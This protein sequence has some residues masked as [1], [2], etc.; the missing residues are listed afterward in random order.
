[1]RCRAVKSSRFYP[2]SVAL[3]ALTLVM[4]VASFARVH[5]TPVPSATPTAGPEN[6]VVTAIA[7]K[8]FLSWQA[9]I[10]DRSKYAPSLLVQIDDAKLKE[11]STNLGRLGP[12]VQVTY[13]GRMVVDHA[14]SPGYTGYLYHFTTQNGAVYEQ[15]VLDP[16]NA[17]AGIIFLDKLPSP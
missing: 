8:Q 11:V 15:L 2:I 9:G 5:A 10:I 3:L 13:L 7:R 6:P 12:P 1:M 14:P 17:V 4:P 16:K